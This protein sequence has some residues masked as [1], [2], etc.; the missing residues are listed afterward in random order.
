MM[1]D[2]CNENNDNNK[3]IVLSI[4][5]GIP[6]SYPDGAEMLLLQ[7][8]CTH[9]DTDTCA[10]A[11]WIRLH[12]FWTLQ[13]AIKTYGYIYTRNTTKLYISHSNE[14]Q[15]GFEYNIITWHIVTLFLLSTHIWVCQSD[16]CAQG[17]GDD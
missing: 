9:R 15:M 2:V 10:H 8:K 14:Y 16:V 12:A 4:E 6:F 7:C 17:V 11:F 1:A 3:S 5:P 13:I